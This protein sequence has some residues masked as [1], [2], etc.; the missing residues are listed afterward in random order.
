MPAPHIRSKFAFSALFAAFAL[1]C[2]L[3][4]GGR[5]SRATEPRPTF[6]SVGV[7]LR[8]SGPAVD[9]A[10]ERAGASTAAKRTTSPPAVDLPTRTAI[11][12]R[13]SRELEISCERGARSL[14]LRIARRA[15]PEAR[16]PPPSDRFLT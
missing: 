13:E 14:P 9:R 12:P 3:L 5:D 10:D 6:A 4:A 15:L 7:A 11:A 1:F 2:A 8:A 16:A